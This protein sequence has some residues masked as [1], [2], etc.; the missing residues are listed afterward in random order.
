MAKLH[1]IEKIEIGPIGVNGAPGASLV[2]VTAI[3]MDS[4]NITIPQVDAENIYVEEVDSVY[5]AL[6]PSEPDPVTMQFA[7]YKADNTT[8]N[9][10]F[11]GVLASGKY[12][13]SRNGVERTVKIYS[14]TRDGVQKVITFPKMRLRPSIEGSLT[15]SAL[16]SVT[17]N[18]TALTPYDASNNALPDFYMEDVV[19]VE[20]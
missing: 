11:G 18:G 9:T 16:T 19:E 2:A 8:L 14:R 6:E 5:D 17:G 13:P 10:I 15:K 4:V 20:E 3:Q 7:T 1:G 12:T